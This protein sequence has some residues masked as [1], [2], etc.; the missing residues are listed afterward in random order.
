MGVRAGR[1]DWRFDDPHAVAGKHII[2]D[3]GELAAVCPSRLDRAPD[4]FGASGAGALRAAGH[5]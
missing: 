5:L 2:E 4:I 1:P 3:A